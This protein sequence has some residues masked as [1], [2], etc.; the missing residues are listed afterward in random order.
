MDVLKYHTY[1][2]KQCFFLIYTC[3]CETPCHP[4]QCAYL[5]QKLFTHSIH[6]T[7]RHTYQW[8]AVLPIL[9]KLCDKFVHFCV[10]KW[11][12]D[13][14]NQIWSW[15]GWWVGVPTWLMTYPQIMRPFCLD[16]SYVACR[17]KT[18]PFNYQTFE[19]NCTNIT[20]KLK[21]IT[22]FCN[23]WLMLC[24]QLRCNDNN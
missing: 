19:T 14:C 3:Q 16:H 11:L 5:G 1:N 9:I 17:V 23:F 21:K 12:I 4:S 2:N 8:L 18:Q 20:A 24:V 10:Q 6:V 13:V 15:L 7:V 22:I